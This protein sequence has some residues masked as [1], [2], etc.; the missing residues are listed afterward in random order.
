M[1]SPEMTA[2]LAQTTTTAVGDVLLRRGR[3]LYMASRIRPLD[4]L[5]RL[6][7]P[8]LTV[9]RKAVELL[10]RGGEKPQNR[11]LESLGRAEPGAVFVIASGASVEVALWGGLLAAAG[12]RGKLG[13]GGGRWPHP[14]PLGNRG[15]EILQEAAAVE[16]RD[17][18]AAKSRRG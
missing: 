9:R 12:V 18:E 16:A 7:G 1:L 4:P 15:A 10:P 8:A 3:Q 5:V 13:G 6:A 14:R 2:L 17:Q 11:F